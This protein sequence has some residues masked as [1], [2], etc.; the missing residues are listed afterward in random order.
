ME[1]FFFFFLGG[2]AAT[3]VRGLIRMVHR[4]G[5]FCRTWNAGFVALSLSTHPIIYSQIVTRFTVQ[6]KTFV[7][8]VA[9]LLGAEVVTVRILLAPF[10]IRAL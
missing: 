4:M 8:A 6:Q 3:G 2:C 10:N 7:P 1:D 9:S 5:R